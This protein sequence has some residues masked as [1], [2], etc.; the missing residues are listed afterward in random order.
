MCPT[1]RYPMAVNTNSPTHPAAASCGETHAPDKSVPGNT[2][3]NSTSYQQRTCCN[4]SRVKGEPVR[5]LIQG[6]GP[7]PSPTAPPLRSAAYAHRATIHVR[8]RQPS[9]KHPSRGTAPAAATHYR[10][11]DDYLFA[12]ARSWLAKAPMGVRLPR[13]ASAMAR[14][15]GWGASKQ[16]QRKGH[17]RFGAGPMPR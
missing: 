7:A 4:Y 12:F 8:V 2:P 11:L 10:A 9:S 5:A 17:R 14:P 13:T 3:R 16:G 6:P 1:V 15:A